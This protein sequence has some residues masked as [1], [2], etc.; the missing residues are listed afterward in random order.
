MGFFSKEAKIRHYWCYLTITIALF[1]GI[2]TRTI[3]LQANPNE[4][5]DRQGE[6]RR[7]EY[8][9]SFTQISEIYD[10]L[11]LWPWL[12]ILCIAVVVDDLAGYV[13]DVVVR[14]LLSLLLYFLV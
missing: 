7:I 6:T 1:S 11:F 8:D 10:Y 14:W 5:K 9:F 12:M 13:N 2:L 3:Y 4:F